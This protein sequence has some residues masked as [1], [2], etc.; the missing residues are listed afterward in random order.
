MNNVLLNNPKYFGKSQYEK[1]TTLEWCPMDS[2]ELFDKNFKRFPKDKT[3]KFYIENPIEYRFNNFGFRSDDDFNTEELGNVFLGCSHTMGIG[4]HIE[5]TW[6]HI[7]NQEVGGKF[8]NLSMG[9]TG[10]DTHF[11]VFLSFYDSLKFKNVFHY[12]PP[13]FRFEYVDNH[14]HFINYTSHS[15]GDDDFFLNNLAN[16][17]NLHLNQVKN[18]LTIKKLCE[19]VGA[20]YYL[21]NQHIEYQPFDCIGARD[22]EHYSTRDQIRLSEI[23]LKKYH[24]NEQKIIIGEPIPVKSII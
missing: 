19:M 22:L 3:L 23:F 20:N 10:L 16:D 15:N 7:V 14:N 11:R 2:K 24:D 4:H 6:S 12:C 8:W 1:D 17:D 18:I 21:V 9:G 13:Y 5:N